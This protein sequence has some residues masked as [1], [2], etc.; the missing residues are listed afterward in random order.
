MNFKYLENKINYDG[1]QLKPLYSYLNHKVVSD[2]IVSFVGS[3]DVTLEHMVD[4]EDY[5]ESSKIKAKEMLHFIVELFSQNIF[6]AVT[7]QR[8]LVSIVH[9]ELLKRGLSFVRSG[10]DL[11]FENKKLSVSIASVSSVS[12]MIHLGINITNEDTPVL[13]CSLKDFG[14][15][16]AQFSSEIMRVFSDEWVT[17]LEATKKVKP[18]V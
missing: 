15:D 10:D 16:P 13:T 8:L 1:S 2:S 5:V 7:A 9:A 4:A 12:A 18:L 14:I 17:I 6:T 3:C 11:Y